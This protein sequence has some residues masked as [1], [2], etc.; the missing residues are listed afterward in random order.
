MFLPTASMVWMPGV[1]VLLANEVGAAQLL[2]GQ[3]AFA[4]SAADSLSGDALTFCDH[5]NREPSLQRVHTAIV[6]QASHKLQV[7]NCDLGVV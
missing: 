6:G 1:C 5:A 7:V 4:H 3:A 2:S